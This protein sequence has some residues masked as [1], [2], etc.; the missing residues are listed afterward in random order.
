M[1]ISGRMP[2]VRTHGFDQRMKILLEHVRIHERTRACVV[3]H[4]L[5]KQGVLFA[6]REHMAMGSGWFCAHA[7][8][9]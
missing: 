5:G 4:S 6:N 7:A 3:S 8:T 1:G 2:L 9:T